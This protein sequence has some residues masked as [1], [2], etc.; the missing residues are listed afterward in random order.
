MDSSRKGFLGA[1]AA[2]FAAAGAFGVPSAASAAAGPMS[3]DALLQL[4][5]KPARHRQVFL[6]SR[7][8]GNVLSY[9]RNALNGFQFGWNEPAGSLHAVA[10]V[11][12]MATTL[13][14]SDQI[15]SRYRLADVLSRMN[16]PLPAGLAHDRN[17]WLRAPGGLVRDDRAIEAPF[18][19]DRSIETLQRRGCD[20]LVCDT[21]LGTVA[22][23]IATYQGG[24]VAAI[25]RELAG[26]L[27]PGAQLVPA[28]VATVAALQEERFTLYDANV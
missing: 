17:P 22:Q 23:M 4:A 18:N 13:G 1:V 12:G 3:Y 5:R 10:V 26:S 16:A 9:M 15:W 28:G 24:N 6:A 2:S 27:I 19:Q 25:H 8:N 20:F 7:P 14:L 21:A 11:N